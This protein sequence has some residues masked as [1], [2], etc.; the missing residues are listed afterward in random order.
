MASERTWQKNEQKDRKDW[1]VAIYMVADGPS[2][3]RVLDQIAAEELLHIV[4]AANPD[5]GSRPLDSIHVAVQAD[6]SDQNGVL[7]FVLGR[8]LEILPEQNAAASSTLEQFLGWVVE[9][10]PSKHFLVL[11]WGHSSGPVGLFG[12]GLKSEPLQRLTLPK[13]AIVLKRF[14]EAPDG[15]STLRR[16]AQALSACEKNYGKAIDL[17]MFKDCWM[18]TLETAVELKGAAQFMIGSQGRVPQVG[19]PYEDIFKHLAGPDDVRTVAEQLVNDL[20]VFYSAA[21]NRAGKDEVPISSVNLSKVDAIADALEQL[22]G[23]IGD[24]RHVDAKK[25][26]SKHALAVLAPEDM[27]PNGEIADAASLLT[28]IMELRDKDES[29]NQRA[30]RLAFEGAALGDSALLDLGALGAGLES[31]FERSAKTLQKAVDAAVYRPRQS[32]FSGLS[33]F[34]YPRMP[35]DVTE[36]FIAPAIGRDASLYANLRL[37]QKKSWQDLA[38]EHTKRVTVVAASD[39]QALAVKTVLS[40]LAGRNADQDEGASALA[41]ALDLNKAPDFAKADLNK[42]LDFMKTLDFNKAPD[43]MKKFDFNKAPDFAAPDNGNKAPDFAAPDNG[44]KAPDF[45]LGESSIFP[46]VQIRFDGAQD[47]HKAPDQPT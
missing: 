5:D 20:N 28:K 27:K 46:M 6:L 15:N 10:C 31:Q 13:A 17:V 26:A 3:N 25:P 42:A 9:Q 45:G 34:Y 2:G 1:T 43:F 29:P 47:G 37:A 41:R 30:T 23:D 35:Q 18:S 44:N 7:R 19:W 32:V 33:V 24:A 38:L 40:V 14:A 21:R 22:A 8:E 39:Q 16:Y 12:D 11:F 4:R 36:S